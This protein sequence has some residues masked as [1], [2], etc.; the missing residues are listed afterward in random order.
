MM[1]AIGRRMARL[2]ERFVPDPLV[3]AL[4][5]SLV[6]ALIHGV[7]APPEASLASAWVRGAGSSA[8]LAFALQMSLV[9]V[10][11]HVLASSR[12]ARALVRWIASLPA[13]AGGAVTLVAFASCVASLIHWGL[14]AICGALLARE[15]GRA[16]HARGIS[17]HYPLLGAA[18]Y[19]GF[20]VWHGGLSGSA[21]L[22]VA[23]RS[24]FLEPLTGVIPLHETLLSPLNLVVTG[25]L[26]VL[27][28]LL[29]RALHPRDITACE[30]PGDAIA[31]DEGDTGH[32]APSQADRVIAVLAGIGVLAA[33]GFALT[34]GQ[35]SFDINTV[36]LLFL[37]AGLLAQGSIARY[38]ASAAEGA[39]G[40][41]A[42]VV[43]F[44]LYFGIIEL[45]REA[46][47]ITWMSESL[48]AISTPLT[49]PILAFLAAGLVNLLVPSGG[50]QWAVQGELLLQAGASHGVPAVTTL[51]A[52]SWGDAWTNMLQPFWALPLLGIMGLQAGRIIGY[53]A[54]VL[55]MMGAWVVVCLV[56]FGLLV[57]AG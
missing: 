36:N 47:A 20:A 50:G 13:T 34:A 27:I 24:H 22:K 55:V 11:G 3:I 7:A 29:L 8:G 28:P 32:A 26:L 35:A 44:P 42:I 51:L 10:T 21:P 40:V 18:G 6:A 17:F 49:F 33:L 37:G 39:R 2:A 48:V 15:M 14:G 41:G 56:A 38:V 46:G 1:D 9:L 54:L 25:G 5:L 52:F 45:L 4:V 43:Q 12:P 23:E 53:I 30:G 19:A 31:A 57:P 16:L